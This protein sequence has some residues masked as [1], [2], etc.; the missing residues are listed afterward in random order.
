MRRILSLVLVFILVFSMA[1][2]AEDT[3]ITAASAKTIT[4]IH[5]NDVHSRVAEDDNSIGYAKVAG[6]ADEILAKSG[7]KPIIADV[8]DALHGQTIATLERGASIVNIMNKVG[9]EVMTP[10]NHDFNYG[11][12]RLLELAA[13]A[14]FKIISSNIEKADGTMFLDGYTI[15]ERDG[16]KIAF[17]GLSTPE[18]AYKTNPK[19]ITGL[20]FTDPVAAAGKM[21]ATL[22]DKADVIICLSHLGL[23]EASDI[24]SRLVAE[25]VAGIDLIIDG[26]SHTVLAEPLK[27]KDTVIVQ[28][29]EYLKNIGVV[30]L[31][32]SADNKITGIT[33]S[34]TT[35]EQ[36]AEIKPNEAV[37]AIISGYAES[38]KPILS[39]VLLKTEID[40]DGERADVR[41]GP[42]NLSGL[43]TKAM[44]DVTG[45]DMAITNGGGI[46]A[47]IKAGDVTRGDIITVLPFGNYI[48]TKKMKGSDI[49]AALENGLAKYPDANGA[50]P[51]VANVEYLFDGKKPA[52]E[53]V[54]QVWIKGVKL[55]AAKEYIVATNDFMAA[56]G[57]GYKFSE[58][59]LV[60]EYQALDEAV[61]AY[62]TKHPELIKY[63]KYTVKEG[64]V[65]WRIARKA[66]HFWLELSK[67][68]KLANPDRIKAGD[69]LL[70]PAW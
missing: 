37:A 17:F 23:D 60:N 12:D 48:V 58:L 36:S 50:F 5:T 46:R 35:K 32:F 68:N 65:L 25:K 6:L 40:L 39:E 4:I 31:E 29:G 45:A 9:Y 33:A 2:F 28:T 18:T 47:S 16:L 66:G 55:D 64:D 70:V 62:V 13:M 51:Q 26:H 41:T 19:N 30:K 69:T 14:S 59:P 43:I 22:K 53:R 63:N 15:V 44:L 49:K 3:S 67:I 24:T 20:S 10:G 21:V 7:I 1:A 11:Q 34:L 54:T 27:I 61:V 42:T 52:G 38:Q 8:G 57:D 56:G